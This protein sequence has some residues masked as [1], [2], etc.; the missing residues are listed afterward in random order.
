MARYMARYNIGVFDLCFESPFFLVK[1]GVYNK[2]GLLGY[3]W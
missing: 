2:K 3:K 1:L